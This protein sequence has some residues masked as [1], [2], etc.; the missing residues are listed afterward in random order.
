MSAQTGFLI[1]AWQ[2]SGLNYLTH[3]SNRRTND[4]RTLRAEPAEVIANRGLIVD[5]K[6]AQLSICN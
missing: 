3:L 1:G 5:I 4:L 2:P 6:L